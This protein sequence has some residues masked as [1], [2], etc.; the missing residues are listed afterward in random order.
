MD[1]NVDIGGEILT[2]EDLSSNM[3]LT[4]AY[5]NIRSFFNKFDD[6]VH[7]LN[8]SEAELFCLGES[9]MTDHVTTDMI[10][11][12][13]YNIFRADRNKNIGKS[14]GGG[15]LLYYKRGLKVFPVEHATKC[16]KDY[17][18]LTVRLELTEVKEIY[19][20]FIW[21]HSTFS[22]ILDV[23][24]SLNLFILIYLTFIHRYLY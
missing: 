18:I 15:L 10:W 22:L 5:W 12:E 23:F 13:G 11:I 7:C 4:I 24:I 2:C 21:K 20:L 9:W 3:G 16:T 8:S 19:Y 14:K 6:F 1:D 17:E